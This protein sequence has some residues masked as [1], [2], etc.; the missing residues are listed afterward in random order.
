MTYI[1]AARYARICERGP[2]QPIGL[3]HTAVGGWR[4]L[5]PHHRAYTT[6]FLIASGMVCMISGTS[7]SPSSSVWQRKVKKAIR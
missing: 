7:T 2:P 5:P 4:M 6:A 1:G 3:H